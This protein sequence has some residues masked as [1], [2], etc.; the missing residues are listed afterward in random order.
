MPLNTII[1]N[2]NREVVVRTRTGTT[3]S[4]KL[5]DYDDHGNVCLEN[6]RGMLI[7]NSI[8]VIDIEVL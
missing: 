7:I 1:K 5:V 4:G 8:V 6:A 2:K 3:Y